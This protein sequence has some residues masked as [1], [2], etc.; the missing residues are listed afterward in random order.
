[1]KNKELEVLRAAVTTSN[2]L[3]TTGYANYLEVITA[4]QGLLEA[5]I[6]LVQIK[7][8]QLQN[9]VQLYRSTGGGWR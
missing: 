9:I 7:K 8:Q 1:L 4:Q 3:F 2:D 5:D 6:E